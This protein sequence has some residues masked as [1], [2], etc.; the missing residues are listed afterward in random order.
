MFDVTLNSGSG[1]MNVGKRIL[2]KYLTVNLFQM[3]CFL[4]VL[5]ACLIFLCVGCD[6]GQEKLT[7]P[8]EE[9]P[10]QILQ[11]FSTTHTESGVTRWKLI[12]DSAEFMKAV[13]YVQNPTIEIFE[14]GQTAIM[15]TGDRGEIIESSNDLKVFDNVVGISRNG[16]IHT[17]EL[18]WRNRDGRLYAPNESKIARGVSTMVGREMEGD[19]SLEVVTMKNVQFTLYSKDENIDTPEQFEHQ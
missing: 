18:H 6:K 19:P 2:K 10:E 14:E 11:S 9:I 16:V 5:T 15:V 8:V 3:N 7:H 17:D 1:C 12:A 4:F 13:A